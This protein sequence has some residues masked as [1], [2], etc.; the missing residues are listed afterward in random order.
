MAYPQVS[1]EG[2]VARRP[3]V[4]IELMPEV[5]LTDALKRQ[6]LEQWKTLGSIPAVADSRILFVTDDNALIPSPR[7]VEIIEKVSR[8]MHPEP[9][10][11]P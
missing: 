9:D 3:E 6:M 7:Y 1:R 4:I 10:V 2:I 5:K 8:I 11:E